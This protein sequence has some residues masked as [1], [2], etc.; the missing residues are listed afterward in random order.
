MEPDEI[1]EVRINKN[2]KS[3]A[4]TA[5]FSSHSDTVMRWTL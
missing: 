5:G 2:T 3:Y 1:F 4:G